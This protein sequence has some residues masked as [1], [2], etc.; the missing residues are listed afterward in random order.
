MTDT[1]Y[2]LFDALLAQHPYKPSTAAAQDALQRFQAA[3]SKPIPAEA[4][5]DFFELKDSLDIL[6][7]Y[8]AHHTFLLGLDLGL[9]IA[10]EL[11]SFQIPR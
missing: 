8:K 1:S 5:H 2:I 11:E 4:R 6:S 3:Q 9:S 10:R 7:Y